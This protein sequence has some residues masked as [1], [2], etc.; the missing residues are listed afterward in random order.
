VSSVILLHTGAKIN[1]CTAGLKAEKF[2]AKCGAK[3]K[4][5]YRI[6]HSAFVN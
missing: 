5:K 4:K 1:P 6:I 3:I 2:N